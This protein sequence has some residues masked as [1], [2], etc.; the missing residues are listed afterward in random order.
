M[1]IYIHYNSS[2]Y[3]TSSSVFWQSG[4]FSEIERL[5][6]DEIKKPGMMPPIICCSVTPSVELLGP[7]TPPVFKPD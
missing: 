5:V 3:A 6:Y 2:L 1:F 7:T 4:D